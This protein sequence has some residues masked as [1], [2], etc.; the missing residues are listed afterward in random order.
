VENLIIKDF[1]LY[2]DTLGRCVY[3]HYNTEEEDGICGK[4]LDIGLK[5]EEILDTEEGIQSFSS[6]EVIYLL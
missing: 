4:V 3:Y 1:K 6:G 5:G 2:S